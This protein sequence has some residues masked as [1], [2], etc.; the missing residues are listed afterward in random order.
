MHISKI[1]HK[2]YMHYDDQTI[3]NLVSADLFEKMADPSLCD[4]EVADSQQNYC[5]DCNL[6]MELYNTEYQCKSCG[7]TRKNETEGGIK[8]HDETITSNIRIMT[9]VNR[10]RF[11]NISG[12]YAKTQRKAIMMQLFQHQSRYTGLK[13]TKNILNATA[14]QYN[15]IQKYITEDE[16][17]VDGKV[18]GQK[19][20]VRRG[21][22][23]DEVLASL[24]YFEGIREKKARKKKDIAIFMGLSTGGFAR[25]ED[26]LR[27][28]EAEG[29][30]D[31]PVNE[32]PIEGFIDRY[33]EA[34]DIENPTYVQFITDMVML[35][36]EKKV[37]MRSQFSSKIVGVIWIII[38]KC[39]LPITSQALEKATDN[40]KKN[41]FNGFC[42]HVFDNIGIFAPIFAKYKIP[43]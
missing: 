33:L 21:N 8:D 12:D 2:L 7:L 6:P 19:K 38:T 34:L 39:K 42:K 16:Y 29:K 9:G 14:T 36:E 30:I 41:T 5:P 23:K 25:G 32:E 10:G 37:G 35:S 27:N 18:S 24:I 22:I 11:Y 40:T 31:I 20:F 43:L 13:F 4:V 15:R 26:I 17:D 1:D 3:Y 28:L